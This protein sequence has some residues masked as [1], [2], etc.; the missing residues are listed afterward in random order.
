MRNLPSEVA[1]LLDVP[2]S[3]LVRSRWADV[4]FK[5]LNMVVLHHCLTPIFEELCA[6]LPAS[7]RKDRN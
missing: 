4:V 2:W 6:Q 3:V 1:V 7:V 5:L